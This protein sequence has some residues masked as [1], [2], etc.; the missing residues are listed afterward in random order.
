MKERERENWEE[1]RK[2]KCSRVELSLLKKKK[3]SAKTLL[4]KRGQNRQ[5]QCVD[6]DNWHA[7]YFRYVV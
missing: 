7:L 4:K 2:F 6:T 3:T 5:I 1:S